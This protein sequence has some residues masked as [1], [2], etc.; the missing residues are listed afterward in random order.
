M[1]TDSL[2]QTYE[3][4]AIIA[5]RTGE[6]Q[7][8]TACMFVRSGMIRAYPSYFESAAEWQQRAAASYRSA[9]YWRFCA[10]QER[11]YLAMAR[12]DRAHLASV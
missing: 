3:T 1:T 2:L 4:N 6:Q 10:V 11:A 7:F 12:A 8:Q 5:Q 9:D